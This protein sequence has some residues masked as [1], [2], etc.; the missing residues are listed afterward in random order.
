[1]DH[2]H[3]CLKNLDLVENVL[4]TN[5]NHLENST[6]FEQGVFLLGSCLCS[7]PVRSH[8]R[9]GQQSNRRYFW[10]LFGLWVQ[11]VCD[12]LSLPSTEV[13]QRAKLLWPI[14]P[15]H[16]GDPCRRQQPGHRRLFCGT[17]RGESLSPGCCWLWRK[18]PGDSLV[19]KF[20]VF[21][22]HFRRE[23][24]GIEKWIWALRHS[25]FIWTNMGVHWNIQ[26]AILGKEIVRTTSQHRE[27]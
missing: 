26:F 24:P 2:N 19:F 13:K 14:I 25:F 15:F 18:K 9:G 3:N 10:D 16:R 8:Q 1:M 5:D 17:F 27:E 11:I 21:V 20:F 12:L 7:S 6:L 23:E 4:L 22:W